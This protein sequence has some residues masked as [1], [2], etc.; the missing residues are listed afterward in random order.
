LSK[1]FSLSACKIPC[2]NT[3][4]SDPGRSLPAVSNQ[5]TSGLINRIA[6]RIDLAIDFLTLGQYGLEEAPADAA[7]CEGGDC[8]A[9]SRREALRPARRRG[10]EPVPLALPRTGRPEAV[11]ATRRASGATI[12]L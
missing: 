7:G 4:T 2:T 12:R 11:P 5:T 3:C 10:C 6:D 1:P 9:G 8:R